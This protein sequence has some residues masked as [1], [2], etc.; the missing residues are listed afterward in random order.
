MS[1]VPGAITREDMYYSRLVNGY[2]SIPQPITRKEHYLH[3]L[4]VN[5]FGS[6]ESVTPEA[7]QAAVDNYMETNSEKF[8]PKFSVDLETGRLGY[9]FGQDNK[10]GGLA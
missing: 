3:Y 5:G 7:V 8:I 4:C 1:E 10:Q 9:E 6:G 2:G